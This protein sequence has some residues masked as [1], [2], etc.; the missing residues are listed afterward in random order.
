MLKL[1]SFADA[2][3]AASETHDHGRDLLRNLAAG[4]ASSLIKALLQLAMLPIMGRLLGPKEF[5]LYAT[6]LPIVTFFTVVADGGLGASL[7]KEKS[8]DQTV[9]T[10][11]FYVMLAVGVV[12]V[13]AVNLCGLALSAFMQEPR[14][15]EL[16]ALLSVTFLF[17]S[18]STLPG[19]RLIQRNDLVSP[20]IIETIATFIGAAAAVVFAFRGWGAISLAV[21]SVTTFGVRAIGLNM[22]AFELPGRK[23]SFKGFA[24]H[25]NTGGVLVGTRLIDMFCRIAENILFSLAFGQ[26]ALGSYTFANQV[27]RFL[28]ESASNPVWHA[29]Y[30]QSLK[31]SG[32]PFA[33][34]ICNMARLMM[35]A[36]F[37]AACIVA[38]AAP[39]VFP[40]LLGAKWQHAGLF[41]Q[42]LVCSYAFAATASV[43][44]AAFLATGENKLFL[45]TAALLSIGRV[46]AVAAGPWLGALEVV[47]AIAI[48][49]LVYA[50]AMAVA[51]DRSYRI[52]MSRLVSAISTPLVSGTVGGLA[53]IAALRM[54]P[55]SDA[56][57]LTSLMVGGVAFVA[58][59]VAI[60]KDFS[61]MNV[62]RSIQRVRARA[63]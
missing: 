33:N 41:L 58:T 26:A 55:G 53:C 63:S 14:L 56:G 4:G 29:T 30:A 16:M 3:R 35:L 47:V 8:A 22:V 45:G 59:L 11:A 20:A 49:H 24:S 48:A 28:C 38:V 43:G 2:Q 6:A 39:D 42:V 23:I 44:S 15:Y 50:V 54:L 34:L 61:V 9:W 46:V 10:T 19:A 13:G 12:L 7:A 1:P 52:D 21:Q 25:L 31:L 62:R 17:I 60:D 36:T 27:C 51:V 5:G 37:P 57:L 32:R 18:A 40:V